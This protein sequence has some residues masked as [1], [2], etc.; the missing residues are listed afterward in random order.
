M[1]RL[2]PTVRLI[3]FDKWHA[4][5]NDFII[6]DAER[7]SREAEQLLCDRHKGIGADGIIYV[8][9][10]ADRDVSDFTLTFANAD[11]TEAEM[12]GNGIRCAGEFARD[13]IGWW[14][15]LKF[16]TKAGVKELHFYKRKKRI[17]VDMGEPRLIWSQNIEVKD[18]TYDASYVDI[19]NPHCVLFV[20]EEATAHGEVE[21]FGPKI[22]HM[23][24]L[25]PEGANVEFVTVKSRDRI[26][27]RVWER[28]V[29]R[30]LACGTGSCASAYAAY[31]RGLVGDHVTVELDGGEVEVNIEESNVHLIG[32]ATFVYRGEYVYMNPLPDD[33]DD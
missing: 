5:G 26:R 30:T 11:G 1:S 22:E 4:C 6:T 12:C 8:E 27:M 23:T 20:D 10:S 18:R 7:M 32:P 33:D 2:F 3:K 15:S 9:T 16:L 31:K 17:G 28:G 21:R 24:S 19:G 25:F 13:Y 14:S 29:G